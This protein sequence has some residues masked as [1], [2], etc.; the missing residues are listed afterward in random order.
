MSRTLDLGLYQAWVSRRWFSKQKRCGHVCHYTWKPALAPTEEVAAH[1]IGIDRRSGYLHF[2][3]PRY[4]DPA[5]RFDQL[6]LR[7]LEAGS[8]LIFFGKS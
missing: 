6:N 7:L 3:R 1:D 2:V 5:I 4:M 8:G